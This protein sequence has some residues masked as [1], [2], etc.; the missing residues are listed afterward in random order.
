MDLL[1][2][3]GYVA[4]ICSTLAFLPQVIRTWKTKSA[5]DISWGLLF[6]FIAGST[7][8]ATYGF[9]K[10]DIPII[11]ANVVTGFMLIALFIMKWCYNHRYRGL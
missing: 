4:G 3:T 1:N 11:A 8:W 5:R 9:I 7:L 6:L 2:Y 10:M